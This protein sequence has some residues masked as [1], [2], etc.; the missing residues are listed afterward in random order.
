MKRFGFPLER[1][2]RWRSE[3]A[4]LEELKLL[5]LRAELDALAAGKRQIQD[6]LTET[7]QQVLG[8]RSMEPLEL[9]SLDSYRFYVR[10]RIREFAQGESQCEAKV[11][12]QRQ[13]VIEARRL[14]ELLDRMRKSAFGKWRTAADKEQEDLAA[15]LFLARGR[16]NA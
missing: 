3:Q 12:E 5:Q 10:G 16:R 2:R 13:K 8:Q 1:V 6:E 11:A 14:F 9:E 7:E 4:A 15:E